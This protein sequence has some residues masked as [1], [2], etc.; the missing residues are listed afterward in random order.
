M[1]R[2]RKAVWQRRRNSVTGPAQFNLAAAVA[3]LSMDRAAEPR[4]APRRRNVLNRETFTGVNTIIGGPQF[5]LPNLANTPR[6]I[7]ILRSG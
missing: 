2:R 5:G 6:K 4:L 1:G 7:Q 3:N